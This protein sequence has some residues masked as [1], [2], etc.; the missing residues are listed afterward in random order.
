MY[1]P[2]L[3]FFTE[4]LH[5]HIQTKQTFF[6]Q[7]ENLTNV[8]FNNDEMQLMNKGL[9]YNLYHKPKR[10]LQTLAMRDWNSHY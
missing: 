8:T 10:W 5:T 7:V 1:L 2:S 3:V 6:K 4:L 9:K